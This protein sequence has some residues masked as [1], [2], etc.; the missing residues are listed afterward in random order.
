MDLRFAL[1]PP[2]YGVLWTKVLDTTVPLISAQDV[3]LVK[4]GD[5]VAVPSRSLQVLCRS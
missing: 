2:R 5:L 3:T 1:P 4:S